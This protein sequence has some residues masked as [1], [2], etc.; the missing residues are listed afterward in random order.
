MHWGA[1]KVTR[2]KDSFC[3][4]I[5]S[6]RD[7]PQF[8]E[9]TEGKHVMDAFLDPDENAII[10]PCRT[11]N[12]NATVLG[13]YLV[14]GKWWQGF[15][16]I[17]ENDPFPIHATIT[18]DLNLL[19]LVELWRSYRW[20]WWDQ[21]PVWSPPRFYQKNPTR[22]LRYWHLWNLWMLYGMENKW[23]GSNEG[24]RGSAGFNLW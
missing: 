17:L 20:N 21:L 11:A 12:F 6:E 13:V 22:R 24:T 16:E 10:I 23:K 3:I 4:I 1:I 8:L 2:I 7:L 5:L 14:C 18:S 19:L 9:T 15:N